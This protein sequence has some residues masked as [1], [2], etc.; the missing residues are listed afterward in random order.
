MVR[1]EF[2]GR[3]WRFPFGFDA[4]SGGLATSEYERNI[5]ESITVI[6]GTKPGERQMLPEFGCRIHELMFSPNTRAT[7][8]LVAHYVEDALVRFEPRIEVTKVDAWPDDT[9]T[10]RVMVHYRIK[11]TKELQEISLLLTG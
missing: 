11:S 4:A 2:L 6:L 8:T 7:A 3:G 9:G 1:R 5:Q 10:L